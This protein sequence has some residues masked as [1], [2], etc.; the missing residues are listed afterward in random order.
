MKRNLLVVIDDSDLD[1]AILKEIFKNSFNVKCIDNV[2]GAQKFIKQNEKLI[3]AIIIDICIGHKNAGLNLLKDLNKN[4]D[5]KQIPNILITSDPNREVV[6]QGIESGAEDFIVKPVDP[7]FV[8]GRIHEIVEEAW[9]KKKAP[10]STHTL[11]VESKPILTAEPVDTFV[12]RRPMRRQRLYP[13]AYRKATRKNSKSH[14]PM[15]SIFSFLP[16]HLTE[17]QLKILTD[18][19]SEAMDKSFRNRSN[20]QMYQH[21]RIQKI[22]EV[23]ARSYFKMY[24]SKECSAEKLRYIIYGSQ[25]YD[26]GLM[27]VPDKIIAKGENQETFNDEKLFYSHTDAAD[28]LFAPFGT[29]H[30]FIKTL[31]EIIEFHHKNLEGKSYPIF[32]KVSEIP[33]SA[34]LVRLSIRVDKYICKYFGSDNC[35]ARAVR[36]LKSEVGRTVSKKVFSAAENSIDQL[37]AAIDE[38][39]NSMSVSFKEFKW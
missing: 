26:I 27:M 1:L 29:E 3:C 14:A 4:P 37:Q 34:Q 33:L 22:T 39:Y 7:I 10:V 31:A 38:T 6:M 19:W 21:V 32:R 12:E 17:E 15:Q 35:A 2:I 16:K 23:F 20:Y 28:I 30:P 13:S 11:P 24:P 36:A 5:T 25:F 18:N 8:T 9:N